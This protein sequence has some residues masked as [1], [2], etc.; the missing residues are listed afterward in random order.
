[1]PTQLT[2]NDLIVPANVTTKYLAGY[3]QREQERIETVYQEIKKQQ[4]QNITGEATP[5]S[6]VFV[7]V[8]GSHGVGKSRLIQSR[9]GNREGGIVLCDADEILKNFISRDLTVNQ[10]D[11]HHRAAFL[12][13][14]FSPVANDIVAMREEL[15][16]P[17]KHWM[18]A[19]EYIRDRL[20]QD[21]VQ[22][23][24][25]VMMVTSGKSKQFGKFLNSVKKTGV[26]IEAHIC[27]APCSVKEAAT[28]KDHYG[29]GLPDGFVKK[30][31]DALRANLATIAASCDNALTIY[32][33]HDA[34]KPLAAVATATAGSYAVESTVAQA[35][36]EAHFADIGGLT[37][38]KLMGQRKLCQPQIAAAP[39]AGIA[40]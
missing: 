29:I 17:A 12:L 40:A 22:E 28:R 16:G 10:D 7:L 23:G 35:G 19:S 5:G 25:P 1:M 9:L 27:E 8:V 33:R 18:P 31:H 36:F 15:E 4:F 34:S 39:Q 14:N 37:V 20:M 11:D 30:E 2:I 32:W 6:S 13:S 38:E 24:Y 26:E 21:A 3:D